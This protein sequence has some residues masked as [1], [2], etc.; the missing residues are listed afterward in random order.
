MQQY[1]YLLAGLTC[2]ISMGLMMW[3]MMRGMGGRRQNQGDLAQ[4]PWDPDFRRDD[5]IGDLTPEA[6]LAVLQV[7]Q[8]RLN[9]EARLLLDVDPRPSRN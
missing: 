3:L 6:K 1:L 8:R 7:R 4:H 9:A 5:D 2:P